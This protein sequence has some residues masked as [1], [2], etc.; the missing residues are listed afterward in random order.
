MILYAA[1]NYDYYKKYAD[2]L[3]KSAE[4]F[5]QKIHIDIFPDVNDKCIPNLNSYFNV[6]I[7]YFNDIAKL[8]KKDNF[9]KKAF[10]ASFRF[11]NL[12]N[13]VNKYN[14]P[15][16][17]VDIDAFIVN[18]VDAINE[19]YDFGLFLRE[20]NN[21][22]GN[23]YEKAGMKVAAG[24]VYVKKSAIGFIEYIENYLLQN[25]MKWFVDQHALYNGY[26]EY[27]DKL[28]FFQMPTKYI[29]WEF[30]EDSFI[31]TGKGPRK[32]NDETY[33]KRFKQIREI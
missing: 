16:L 9:D 26:K 17:V 22:G 30:K 28:N 24:A 33:L 27:K 13:I 12:K 25:E 21:D 31:W 18:K 1:C 29:D 20:N 19:N 3:I 23:E 4:Q 6:D 15:I 14:E 11:L 8:I 32:F 2:V 5:N 7:N 10:Y